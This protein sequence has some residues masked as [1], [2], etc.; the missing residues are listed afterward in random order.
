MDSYPPEINAKTLNEEPADIEFRKEVGLGNNA[1]PLPGQVLTTEEECLQPQSSGSEFDLEQFRQGNVQKHVGYPVTGEEGK[2]EEIEKSQFQ[3]LKE[4]QLFGVKFILQYLQERNKNPVLLLQCIYISHF[5]NTAIEIVTFY[6]GLKF[7]LFFLF[8]CIGQ[9]S[10]L[11]YFYV[12]VCRMPISKIKKFNLKLTVIL[13]ILG[14]T[15]VFLLV[16]GFGFQTPY[17]SM[18]I[19]ILLMFVLH[20]FVY[21]E[22]GLILLPNNREWKDPEYQTRYFLSRGMLAFFNS[23]GIVDV[24]SDVALGLE[25]VRNFTGYVYGMGIA[26]FIL[27]AMDY[28][29]LNLRTAQPTKVTMKRH[30]ITV[31]IELLVMA[32]TASVIFGVRSDSSSSEETKQESIVIIAISISTTAVNFLHHVFLIYDQCMANSLVHSDLSVMH[33]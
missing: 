20:I 26:L 7:R 24:Y 16:Y 5:M 15:Q 19:F 25:L 29:L 10:L 14:I 22:S 31:G 21:F 13:S 18:P 33:G 8:F 2:H 9:M 4:I 12:C 1:Y 28:I 27:C 6:F 17:D 32:L 30:V 11:F 23:C 3:E